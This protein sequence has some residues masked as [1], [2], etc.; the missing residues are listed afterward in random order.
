MS[1]LI[2]NKVHDFW[3]SESCGE[4]YTLG[5][6]IAEKFLIEKKNRY[7]LEPYNGEVGACH[8]GLFLS[9][10]KIFYPRLLIKMISNFFPIVLYL[11]IKVKK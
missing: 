9:L 3:N 1:N 7:K 2:I 8:K 6:N 10:A 4:R 11:F 5:D